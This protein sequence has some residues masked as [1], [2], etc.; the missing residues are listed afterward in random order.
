MFE[1]NMIDCIFLQSYLK[2]HSYV[3][4]FKEIKSGVLK[5]YLTRIVQNNKLTKD[6]VDFV[7]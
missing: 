1:K 6:H 2:A 7:L 4:I 5:S 3:L